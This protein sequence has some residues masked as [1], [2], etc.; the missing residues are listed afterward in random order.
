MNSFLK[1]RR[2]SR[3]IFQRGFGFLFLV[4]SGPVATVTSAMMALALIVPTYA[5]GQEQ[6]FPSPSVTGVL[7]NKDAGAV[8]ELN[9]YLQG[10][11]AAGWQSLEGAGTLTYPEGDTHSATLYLGGSRNTRLDIFMDF[12]ARS[13]RIKGGSGKYEDESGIRGTLPVATSVTGVLALPR[14]WIDALGSAPISLFDHGLFTGAGQS[15]HRISM[16]YPL[17]ADATVAQSA[18]VATDLYFDPST[19]L[20]VYSVDLVT[21]AESRGQSL[22]KVTSYGNYQQFSGV[23]VPTTIQQRLNGQTQWTLHLDHITINTTLPLSTFSF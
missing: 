12:G 18:T 2:K 19:H 6:S 7:G 10:V 4:M 23:L 21:F 20:L 11:S 16:E 9:A 15:L 8:A 3:I 22:T 1:Q 5:R 14:V 13:L 17:Y